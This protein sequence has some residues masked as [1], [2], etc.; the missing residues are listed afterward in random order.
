MADIHSCPENNRNF[1]INMEKGLLKNKKLKTAFE[2]TKIFVS[3]YIFLGFVLVV[4]VR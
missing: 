3:K 1:L 2:K 4:T